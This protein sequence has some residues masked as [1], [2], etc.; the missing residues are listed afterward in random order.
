M[1]QRTRKDEEE[2]AGHSREIP[3]QPPTGGIKRFLLS[4]KRRRLGRQGATEADR[5][6]RKGFAGWVWRFTHLQR[7]KKVPRNKADDVVAAPQPR[8][9]PSANQSTLQSPAGST[10]SEFLRLNTEL[11]SQGDR[12]I[13]ADFVSEL[14]LPTTANGVG[15]VASQRSLQITVPPSAPSKSGDFTDTGSSSQTVI[16]SPPP[17]VSISRE[18]I[19]QPPKPQSMTVSIEDLNKYKFETEFRNGYPI[20]REKLGSGKLWVTSTWRNKKMIGTGNFG[21]VFLQEKEELAGLER[22]KLRAVK[23]LPKAAISSETG[24]SEELSA[25]VR[26][27]EVGFSNISMALGVAY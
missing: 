23:R 17:E 26:L 25:L 5:P 10:D 7:H 3:S 16:I 9:S 21:T 1:Q 19:S 11:P 13:A 18:S 24:P 27:K 22:K 15:G 12:F 2:S 4:R 8:K 14:P 6:R 20:H